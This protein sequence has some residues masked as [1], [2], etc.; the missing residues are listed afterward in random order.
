MTIKNTNSVGLHC[1]LASE[2]DSPAN[3]G[4]LSLAKHPSFMHPT[5]ETTFTPL[6]ARIGRLSWVACY[7]LT[8][9]NCCQLK[10]P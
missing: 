3:L 10:A 6:A 2:W 5:F 8:G 4:L 7:S 1:V 9:S